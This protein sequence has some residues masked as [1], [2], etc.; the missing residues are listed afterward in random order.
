MEHICKKCLLYEAG[1]KNAYKTVK[2]YINNLDSEFKVEEVIY[3]SRLEKCKSCDFLISGMCLKCG[4]YAEI[5]AVFKDKQ[6]PNFDN[7]KW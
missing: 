5:R 2:D 4:C 6:C 1:E 3:N 7:Q